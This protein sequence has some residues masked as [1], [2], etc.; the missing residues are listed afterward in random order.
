MKSKAAQVHF[1]HQGTPVADAFDDVYFSNDSGI[2]E[3]QYVFLGGNDIQQ[4]WLTHDAAHFVVAETGFGT[5]LNCLVVMKAFAEFRQQHP[6]HP[7]KQ[8]N[9][10][11]CEKF[12][13]SPSDIATALA[14]F[15]TVKPLAD[16]LL[17]QYPVTID[18]C[19]RLVFNDWSCVLDIW[20]GDVHDVMPQWHSPK[21]GLVDAWFLDGFAPSKNPDMWSETLFEQMARVSKTGATLATFTAAGFVKRGLQSVGFTMKKRKGFGRKRDMLIGTMQAC[22]IH[23]QSAPC[24]YRYTQAMPVND[25][26]VVGGGLAAA[27]TAL[28]LA[29]KGVTVTLYHD[30]DVLAQGASGNPQGGFYPQLHAEASHAS[31]IQ[32]HGFLFARRFY[33]RLLTQGAVFEHQWCGVALLGFTEEMT[34]RLKK[35]THSGVWPDA[36]VEAKSIN[37]MADITQI[38]THCSGAYIRHGGWLSPPQ[39]VNSIIALAKKTGRLQCKANHRLTACHT[40]NQADGVVLTF[41]HEKSTQHEHLVLACGHESIDLPLLDVL[42]LNPV[43][44]QVE[45]LP[46]QA[47]L[48]KLATVLCHKG[49]M[50]PVSNGRH[51]LG[52]TYVKRD[53]KTDVRTEESE[54]NL[55]THRKA[56]SKTGWPTTLQHDGQARAA[57]RLGA[58]DHQPISGRLPNKDELSI[59]LAPL[60][61][62]IGLHRSNTPSSGA[63]SVMTALGSRGLTTG[64]LAA[65]ILASELTHQPLPMTEVLL[66]ALHPSRFM[67]RD[68][69]RGKLD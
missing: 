22:R 58:P 61:K 53:V 12:P 26:A 64:P 24:Y 34:A 60:A 30:G 9:I 68:A 19:H 63:V 36:L 21:H 14:F 52:S 13:L 20:L 45:A 66:Q 49:Y 17:A 2:D 51:A 55:N 48:D 6:T 8:L 27:Y 35:L 54:A 47:P 41:N 16:A 44:G 3:T 28:T 67:V 31:Q 56:L 32:A 33:D 62:G 29:E 23:R 46:T 10:I 15:P 7:L 1:N 39:L 11:T 69:I 40:E 37:E 59:T 25:V 50:T 38:E 18:G 57:I 5:G 4:R 42:P 65:E 43:R